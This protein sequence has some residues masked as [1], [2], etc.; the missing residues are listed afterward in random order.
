M[1]GFIQRRLQKTVW[2]KASSTAGY[3][4]LG[5]CWSKRHT[6]RIAVE[7]TWILKGGVG[8]DR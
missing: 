7:S 1:T 2:H 4:T 8:I 6:P 3:T 5:R